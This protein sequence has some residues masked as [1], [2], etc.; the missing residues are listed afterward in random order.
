MH[1]IFNNE[2]FN[3]RHSFDDLKNSD[4][5]RAFWTIFTEFPKWI[6]QKPHSHQK[7]INKN[8]SVRVKKTIFLETII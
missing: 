8:F 5:K 7:M 2:S 3:Y 4:N 6:R 1:D